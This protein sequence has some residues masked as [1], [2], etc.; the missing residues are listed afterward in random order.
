MIPLVHRSLPS[1]FEGT[2]VIV[3]GSNGRSRVVRGTA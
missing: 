2:A 1:S 3:R